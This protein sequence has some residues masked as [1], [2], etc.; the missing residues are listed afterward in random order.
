MLLYVI[1]I[2]EFVF[3]MWNSES[4]DCAFKSKAIRESMVLVYPSVPGIG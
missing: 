3:S 4:N 2:I 1:Y